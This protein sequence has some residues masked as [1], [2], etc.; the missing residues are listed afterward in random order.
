VERREAFTEAGIDD[1]TEYDGDDTD[2][3]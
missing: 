3:H 2:L 1:K